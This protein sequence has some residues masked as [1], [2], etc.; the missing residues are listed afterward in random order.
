MSGLDQAMLING[1]VLFAVL[2]ADL[3]PN[4]KVGKFRILRPL[5]M[6]AGIIPL[7]LTSLATRG[8]ALTLEVACTVAG[9]LFGLLAT[10]LTHVYLS[11]RTGRPVSHA[12]F[13][14]A[15]VWIAVI[16]ARAAFS[17]GSYHWFPQQL[18]RWMT[19][20]Q[21]TPDALTNGLILMAVAMMLTRTLTLA[22]RAA[23]TRRQPLVAA[24]H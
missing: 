14:Y 4:R 21:I 8:S 3:G 10:R 20:Q 11:P 13:G 18:G 6:A 2:E 9:L 19:T 22:A 7:Y 5:L 17:Y 1:I 15:A 23:A 24:A 12:G 16:G